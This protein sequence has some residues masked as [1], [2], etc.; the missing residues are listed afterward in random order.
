M[1][2]KIACVNGSVIEII[3]VNGGW[4]TIRSCDGTESKVRNGQVEAVKH[5]VADVIESIDKQ[6]HR[7]SIVRGKAAAKSL[8]KLEADPTAIDEDFDTPTPRLRTC[9]TTKYD[10]ADYVKV[11]SSNGNTSMDK[12]D[13]LA[14]KLRQFDLD[15]IYKYAA[16]ALGVPEKELR[17]RYAHLNPGLVRMALGNRLRAI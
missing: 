8:A 14:I 5:T 11:K 17:T 6:S 7:N 10:P 1:K 13:A 2:T 16:T 15:G 9:G 12:G 3:A 4:T